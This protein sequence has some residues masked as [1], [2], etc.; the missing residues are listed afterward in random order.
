MNVISEIHKHKKKLRIDKNLELPPKGN[1]SVL[2]I[3]I[4]SVKYSTID[5]YNVFKSQK[6]YWREIFSV[7]ERGNGIDMRGA[8]IK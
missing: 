3:Y 5:Y 6:I 4:V 7:N 2:F 1:H 8:A